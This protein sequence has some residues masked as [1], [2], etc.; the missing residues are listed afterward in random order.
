M[1]TFDEKRILFA[2]GIGAVVIAAAIAAC[3]GGG[4]N[5]A[6]PGG[7]DDAGPPGTGGSGGGGNDVDGGAPPLIDAGSVST[8]PGSCPNPTVA[9]FFTP[10]YSAIIPGSS[11]HTFSIPAITGDGNSA[12]WSLSD[13]TQGHLQTQG[14]QVDGVSVPGVLVTIAGTGNANGDVT[15]VADE[16]NG[17]CGASVL[18]ITQNSEDDWN[19]GNARYNDGVGITVGSNRNPDGGRVLPPDGG[20]GGPGMSRDAGSIYET[21]GG[22]ACTN[23]HGPTATMGPYRTVSH[24]PEQAGG[25]SDMDLQNI[26]WNGEVPDG[27]Y[28]DPTVLIPACDGGATCTQQ[29]RALWH[30]FHRWVDITP[31]QLPGVI[32]YLRSLTPQAQ[33]GAPSFG[34]GFNRDGGFGM[35][36]GGGR[37]NRDGGG[38]GGP[39]DAGPSQ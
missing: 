27:G 17:V 22:T 16:G 21:E 14:F 39:R 12:T 20:R 3:S 24:T 9:I 29:A 25:F 2:V 33:T 37:G 30:S 10:M 13:P 26:I 15:L 6:T 28:F 31:D 38:G 5:D 35:R 4:S 18:H 32:C 7:G 11:A 36:D 34:G 1:A 23:C 19:I 8:Q